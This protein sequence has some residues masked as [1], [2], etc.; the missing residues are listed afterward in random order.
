MDLGLVIGLVVGV[1]AILAAAAIS[2]VPMVE[3]LRSPA[4]LALL[5]S[6]GAAGGVAWF[7]RGR[8]WGGARAG[9]LGAARQTEEIVRLL[10]ETARVVSSR[11]ARAAADEARAAGDSLLAGGLSLIET[12]V[13]EEALRRTLDNELDRLLT[14]DASRQATARRTARLSRP[15][16]ML[17]CIAGLGMLLSGATSGQPLTPG[18]SAVAVLLLYGAM[19]AIVIVG[20]LAERSVLRSGRRAFVDALT[21]CAVQ[22]IARG[23]S[24]EGVERLLRSRLPSGGTGG[25]EDQARRAA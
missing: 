16:G 4:M 18:G 8:R 13:S 9:R 17:A 19:A 10:I 1:G 11:G 22:A 6:L 20:P 23:E 7:F 3:A 21:V 14:I 2:G 24:P 12:G 5:G 25:A 15:F